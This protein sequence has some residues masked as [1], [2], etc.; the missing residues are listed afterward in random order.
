MYATLF[1]I[2]F[3]LQNLRRVFKN[4]SE[5]AMNENPMNIP[6]V[7]PMFPTK[8]MALTMKYS[9]MTNFTGRVDLRSNDA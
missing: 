1:E 5:V 6:R 2:E 3:F 9:F 4:H 7:P 8:D